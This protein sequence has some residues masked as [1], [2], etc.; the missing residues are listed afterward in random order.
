VTN[1]GDLLN[2][3]VFGN[4]RT[5]LGDARTIQVWLKYSF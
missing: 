2:P 3:A 5:T 1:Y 4:P